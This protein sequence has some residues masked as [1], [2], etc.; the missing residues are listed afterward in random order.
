M[1]HDILLKVVKE[2]TTSDGRWTD[3][4][5]L[6]V[7][8]MQSKDGM[9]ICPMCDTSMPKTKRKCVNKDCGVNLK[10]AEKQA[11]GTDI[12]GT[13]L[14]APV[15]TFQHR[16][17]ETSLGF[18]VQENEAFVYKKEELWETYDEW[19]DVPSRHPSHPIKVE[20]SDPVFVNP[21]SFDSVKEVL[22]RVGHAASVSRYHP[23]LPNARKWL[24]VTMDGSPYLVSRTV[25]DAVYLCCDCETE[26][27]KSKQG[28]HCNDVHQGRRVNF[29]K[30][31][32]WVLLRIG[33]LHLEMNMAKTFTSHNWEV[34]MC[35]LTKEL[36]FTSEAAQK[37]VKKCSD[38]HKT[39]SIL[40]VAH[41]GFWYEL[42]LPYVRN[43]LSSGSP[44]S[45]NDFLYDWVRQVGWNNPNYKYIFNTTWTYLMGIQ[46]LHIG[47][48]RN[49]AEY[50]RAGHMTFAPLF[51]GNC[52]SK[53]ALIDLHDR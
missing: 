42:L 49:N 33:K 51:H 5:D 27:L 23:N 9:R 30:E 15:R 26:V 36:G 45:V 48:R 38:H 40:K 53:Y 13:A 10:S 25:I 8:E 1:I 50:I 6:R 11:S 19:T 12:L 39:M 31:F 3:D 44:M 34:F 46:L 47:V 21:N 16:M 52:A 14:I 35:E 43:R 28:D 41:I 20:T 7:A 18:Q 22:R 4:I 24:S 37:Y 29:I 2:Q 32:D 17:H